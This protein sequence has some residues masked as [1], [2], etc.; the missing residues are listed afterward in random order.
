MITT[1]S[2]EFIE[3]IEEHP[4]Y[5]DYR[6]LADDAAPNEQKRKVKYERFLRAADNV[7]LAEN[8]RRRKDAK[9]LEQYEAIVQ[10]EASTL[11]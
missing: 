10:A 8:L 9:K 2:D 7:A 6:K 1:R 4:N 5:S 11:K 3:A